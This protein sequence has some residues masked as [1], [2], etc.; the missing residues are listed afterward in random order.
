MVRPPALPLPV[1]HGS[2]RDRITVVSAGMLAP[3]KRDHALARCQQYLNYGA[4]SL[5]TRLH[6]DGRDARLVHGGHDDQTAFVERLATRGDLDTA[7]PI[8]LSIP[9]FQGLPLARTF[10]REI[11]ARR[12]S[13]RLVVGGRWVVG[14]DPSWLADRIPEA[15]VLVSG[16]AEDLIAAL[17]DG[18]A[19]GRFI[20][21]AAARDGAG[22]PSDRAFEHRLVEGYEAFRPSVEASRGCGVRCAFCEER[23]I[24][25][26]ALKDP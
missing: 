14:A 11:K 13:A 17:V 12:P 5:A 16:L 23:D 10:V 7:M 24:P 18:S 2:V 1:A 8:M 9:S 26:S 6:A 4:L 3:K 25:L 21:G 20:D 19:T 15:D 22:R